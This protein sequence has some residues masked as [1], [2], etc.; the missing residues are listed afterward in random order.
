MTLGGQFRTSVRSIRAVAVSPKALS[1]G[2]PGG[3]REPPPALDAPE[4]KK[5]SL[6]PS[7]IRRPGGKLLD[8]SND[9]RKKWGVETRNKQ[10]GHEQFRTSAGYFSWLVFFFEFD[11]S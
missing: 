3:E 9:A 5:T 1:G 8:R 7:T 4:S 11:L 6:S 2:G 10:Y